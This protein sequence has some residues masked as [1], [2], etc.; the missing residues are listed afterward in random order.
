MKIIKQIKFEGVCDEV[1][2]KKLF[3][4]TIIQKI[5]ERNSSFDV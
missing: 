2:S 1:R 3:P 4:K 5:F